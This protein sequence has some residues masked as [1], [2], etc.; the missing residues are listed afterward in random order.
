MEN[1]KKKT[2]FSPEFVKKIDGMIFNVVY[3]A[4]EKTVYDPHVL[5]KLDR[6]VLAKKIFFEYFTIKTIS[7]NGMSE[8]G[9]A[10]NAESFAQW[11]A[12][13][14]DKAIPFVALYEKNKHKQG[15]TPEIARH[16]LEKHPP[17][18]YRHTKDLTY[19]LPHVFEYDETDMEPASDAQIRDIERFGYKFLEDGVSRADA[20][21]LYAYLNT[22]KRTTKPYCFNYY[23]QDISQ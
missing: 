1:P 18:Y 5:N 21:I 22:G 3:N 13:R 12:Q 2:R 7:K 9:G 10:T 4:D 16:M 11:L 19:Q 20:T 23:L 15:F 8:I 6:H 14:I 17:S